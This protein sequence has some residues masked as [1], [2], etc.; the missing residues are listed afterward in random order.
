MQIQ[1]LDLE[2]GTFRTNLPYHW[3]GWLLWAIGLVLTLAGVVFAMDETPAI[4]LS[5]VGLIVMAF[6]SPGSLEA[7]LHKVRQNAIDPSELQAKAE[8]SGLSM[9]RQ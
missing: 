7:S 4:G 3:I 1:D 9:T 8:A 5:A 2:G 6:S